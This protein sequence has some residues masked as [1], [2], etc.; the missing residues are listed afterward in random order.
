MHA[1]PALIM[2]SWL[3][4]ALYVY[5]YYLCTFLSPTAED[6]VKMILVYTLMTDATDSRC[7]VEILFQARSA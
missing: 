2:S 3:S 1:F 4:K 5:D 7:V 6:V